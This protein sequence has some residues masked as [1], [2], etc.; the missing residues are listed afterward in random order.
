[1]TERHLD[2]RSAWSVADGTVRGRVR[3]AIEWPRRRKPLR[4]AAG[5]TGILDRHTG[6]CLGYDEH[7]RGGPIAVA[8][9][10]ARRRARCGRAGVARGFEAHT[11][12]G[13]KQRRF[14]ARRIE[15][16]NIERAPNEVPA[17]RRGERVDASESASD[18]DAAGGNEGPRARPARGLET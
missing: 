13:P 4:Q 15:E 6:T 18:P 9:G 7:G 2:R 10:A 17:A 3:H 8:G 12:A 14:V 16:H 5:T 11:V 1:R